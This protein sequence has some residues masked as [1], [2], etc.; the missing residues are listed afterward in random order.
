MKNQKET[1]EAQI[2]SKQLVLDISDLTVRD[3]ENLAEEFVQEKDVKCKMSNIGD[4]PVLIITKNCSEA[5]VWQKAR[6]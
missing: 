5:I 4:M 2:I 6:F 3:V 1:C